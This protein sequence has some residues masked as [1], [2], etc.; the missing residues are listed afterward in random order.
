MWKFN[1]NIASCCFGL[2]MLWWMGNG[3]WK[4]MLFGKCCMHLFINPSH[5]A[6][7]RGRNSWKIPLILAK[8]NEPSLGFVRK[9][10]YQKILTEYF[11]KYLSS[12][13]RLTWHWFHIIS[14][15]FPWELLQYI[16]LKTPMR[17]DIC[18]CTEPN[19]KSR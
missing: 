19:R 18:T 7:R 4:F 8:N 17:F 9:L 1:F 12:L 15:I 14:M 13:L 3:E 2:Q 5:E 6:C 16:G 11:L 10:R